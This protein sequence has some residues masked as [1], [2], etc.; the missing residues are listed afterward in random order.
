[1]DGEKP[2]LFCG[3]ERLEIDVGV[4]VAV[5]L[6]VFVDLVLNDRPEHGAIMQIPVYLYRFMHKI[7]HHFGF[8]E[9][10]GFLHSQNFGFGGQGRSSP[11]LG[12]LPRFRAMVFWAV[13]RR[14]IDGWW[15]CFGGFGRYSCGL[16]LI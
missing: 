11:N 12:G 9:A 4:A 6:D 15:R 7:H 16:R 14:R 3:I 2:I 1:M 10:L 5:A 13:I 8:G